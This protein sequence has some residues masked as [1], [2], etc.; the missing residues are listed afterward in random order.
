MYR[1]ILRRLLLI[2]FIVA[3]VSFLIF[4]APLVSGIDPATA[5][6]QAQ[7][8]DRQ[9]TPEAIERLKKELGLDRHLLVQ[10][11]AWLWRVAQGDMGRSYMGRVPV[12]ERVFDGLKVSA[13]LSV[14]TMTLSLG[15]SLPLG[16]L[17]AMKPGTLLDTFVSV[18]SQLGVVVP[19]YVLAP[20]LILVFG[21]HLGWL[22]S[23]GWRGP[24]HI[25]LPCLTLASGATAFFTQVVRAS[26][27]EAL[28]MEYMRTARAKGLGEGLLVRRH[29]L[30][31]AMIPVVTLSSMWLAGL[32][33]G[34][35]IVEV[36]FAVPGIG[37]VLF[38][39]IN[40]SDLPLIQG[41]LMTIV[42]IA[43]L[44]NT[45]TDV[46]YVVLNPAIRLEG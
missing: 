20:T 36:I 41:S 39:A 23:A 35:L 4:L 34:A 3:V 43:V 26:M 25:V 44:V 8:E 28:S 13:T 11:G 14:V 38:D 1:L 15:V 24:L 29:A 12:S 30:R 42:I 18:A 5:V 9:P 40:A 6:L 22:P 31:N 17:A 32:I 27:I 46:I 33:G 21:I 37:R 2:P 16:I 7:V 45:A 10:Y 19:A